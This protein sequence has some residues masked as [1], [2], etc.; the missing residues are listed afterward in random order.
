MRSGQH[1]SFPYWTGTRCVTCS[2]GGFAAQLHGSSLPTTDVDVT[3]A[4]DRENLDRLV[5]A[6]RELEAGVR[7]D[8]LPD[9]LPLDTSA[10]AL[11]GMKTLNPRTP[12]GD[13]DLTISPDGTGGYADLVR[14]AAPRRFGGIVAQARALVVDRRVGV[15]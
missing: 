8:D 5:A 15:A 2:S 10:D 11:A 12:H 1:R 4:T 7:V 3:P 9:G 14:A 13:I 6:L